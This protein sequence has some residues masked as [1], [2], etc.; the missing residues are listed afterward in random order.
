MARIDLEDYDVGEQIGAGTVGT[1]FR[2]THKQSGDVRAMKFLSPGVSSNELIVS[3]F[4]REMLILEK[5]DHPNILAYYGGGK[6]NNQLFFIMELVTGGTLKDL[7]ADGGPLGWEE[8]AESI[9]Q[10]AGALQHA[11]NHGIIHRDLK[12]G[13][14]FVTEQGQLKLGDFGIARDTQEQAL[15]EAGLTVG[16]YYYMAPELVRGEEGATGQVDLY[17]LGC[18]LFELLT[19]SPPFQ[20][21][22]FA[23]IFDQHLKAEP[24][25]VRD[26]QVEC[27]AQI[28]S[29]IAHLLAKDPD[30]RP[31]NARWVQGY[32]GD[33]L[34]AD[35]ESEATLV[36]LSASEITAAQQLLSKR[37][38][39]RHDVQPRDVSWGKLAMIFAFVVVLILAF[40]F[41]NR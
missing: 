20:G 27:P 2:V 36:D 34:Q 37:V 30:Q 25:R 1:I 33:L 40:A 10:L 18:V 32:L 7:L 38:N 39:Q 41:L 28:D 3:R 4:A 14:V 9:R 24:P 16:T 23:Q 6:D 19:G 13:N 26:Y 22:N 31:F 35:S 17:A 8:A 5:L 12:P 15:T 21:N 11:H 29:L